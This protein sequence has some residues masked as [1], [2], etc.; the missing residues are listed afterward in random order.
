[1]HNDRE[2]RIMEAQDQT[3]PALP[4]FFLFIVCQ[5]QDVA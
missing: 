1:M 2:N 3:D 4:V 5:S